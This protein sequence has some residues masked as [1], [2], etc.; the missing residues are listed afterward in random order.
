MRN[1]C[2][3]IYIYISHSYIIISTEQM[4]DEADIEANRDENAE[5]QRGEEES[6]D[7]DQPPRHD[8]STGKAPCISPA[9][10]LFL[11]TPLSRL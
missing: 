6:D 3:Y 9:S 8:D 10:T 1:K 7:H 2:V 11:N 5:S 4:V